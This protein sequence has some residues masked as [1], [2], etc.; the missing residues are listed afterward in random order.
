MFSFANLFGG[1]SK[2]EET[3]TKESYLVDVR[4]PLEFN[5][6]SVPGAVNL[7]LDTIH[8]HADKLKNKKHVVVFCRSGAR[9]SQAQSILKRKG[10]NNVDNGGTW[11]SVA[12]AVKNLK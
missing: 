7:P 6:G 2:L 4:S 9:S 1:S 12:Q 10:L 8:Q 11:Q 5:A 3:L